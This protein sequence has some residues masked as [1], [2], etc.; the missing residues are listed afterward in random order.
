MA[1]EAGP[2]GL[3][4]ASSEFVRC[5]R[6]YARLPTSVLPWE[7]DPHGSP[8]FRTMPRMLPLAGA[9]IGAV[10]RR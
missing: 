7:A 2:T 1:R 5:L 3:E 9:A 4:A 10:G 8:D 6:F